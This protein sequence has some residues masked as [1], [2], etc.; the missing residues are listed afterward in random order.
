MAAGNISE[1]KDIQSI[2][3]EKYAFVFLQLL[4]SERGGDLLEER[5]Q[6]RNELRN[7]A[8]VGEVRS[9]QRT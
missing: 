1:S 6:R 2:K 5:P 3:P 4:I 8:Q 9:F 7:G